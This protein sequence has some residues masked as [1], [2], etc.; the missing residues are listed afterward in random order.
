MMEM[1]LCTM[2]QFY[3]D[4]NNGTLR[5]MFELLGEL[6]E[7]GCELAI[8]ACGQCKHVDWFIDS[9]LKGPLTAK[10]IEERIKLAGLVYELV[11]IDED[12]EL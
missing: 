8:H 7:M 5:A 6:R 11:V 3:H 4:D 10:Q 2:V 1:K 9:D 12:E